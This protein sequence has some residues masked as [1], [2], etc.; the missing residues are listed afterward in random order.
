M[1]IMSLVPIVLGLPFVSAIFIKE[2]K[3]ASFEI[4]K[5]GV[6]KWKNTIMYHFAT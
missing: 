5:N 2:K 3:N 4:Q 6:I 1:P